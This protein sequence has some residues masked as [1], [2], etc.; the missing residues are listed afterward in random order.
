[1]CGDETYEER[2]SILACFICWLSVNF[3]DAC[4]SLNIVVKFKI[5]LWIMSLI[6]SL[7]QV[8]HFASVLSDRTLAVTDNWEAMLKRTTVAFALETVPLVDWSEAKRSLTCHL[9][10]VGTR[11]HE[12]MSVVWFLDYCSLCWSI[13]ISQPQQH[14]IYP[15]L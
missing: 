1:M 5:L 13:P 2:F 6:W 12:H 7:S 11:I 14:W 10:N 9:K 4:Q 3:Y 15:G 8:S